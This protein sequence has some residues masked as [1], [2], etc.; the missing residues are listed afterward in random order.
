MFHSKHNSWQNY[1]NG[2]TPTNSTWN[3]GYSEGY[4]Y[5]CG[6]FSTFGSW[7]TMFYGCGEFIDINRYICIRS[8]GD[9]GQWKGQAIG[10]YLHHKCGDW[11]TSYN[12]LTSIVNWNNNRISWIKIKKNSFQTKKISPFLKSFQL[13]SLIICLSNYF[14]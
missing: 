3:T 1:L 13:N 8:G 11:T 6:N 2:K 14:F 4:I 10:E 5:W 9:N 12:S 7:T